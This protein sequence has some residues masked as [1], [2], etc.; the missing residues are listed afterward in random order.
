MC[1]RY[2]AW[3]RRDSLRGYS[4]SAYA[5][6]SAL[7]IA[8]YRC[9]RGELCPLAHH[10]SV[11]AGAAYPSTLS[12]LSR[13]LLQERM[14]QQSMGS[15][16]GRVHRRMQHSVVLCIPGVAS[17]CLCIPVCPWILIHVRVTK[18]VSRSS[19]RVPTA[20]AMLRTLLLGA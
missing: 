3:T 16:R 6:T 18:P 14:H 19:P 20:H 5:Y 12:L 7:C 4:S 2:S 11:R 8:V 9:S 1:I 10:G 17:A 15:L 13:S